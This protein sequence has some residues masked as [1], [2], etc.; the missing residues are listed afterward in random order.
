LTGCSSVP[1]QPAGASATP[2]MFVNY[3][4]AFKYIAAQERIPTD[5]GTLFRLAADSEI[6][7][8]HFDERPPL[9]VVTAHYYAGGLYDQIRGA[10]DNGRFYV[11]RTLA[12]DFTAVGNTDHG[13]QLIG[14]AEGNSYSWQTVNDR[15][16]LITRWHMSAAES[17]T[18][19]YDWEGMT[20][21]RSKE[22]K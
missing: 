4:A 20:Q 10:Q 21:L 6:R 13:F 7:V 19:T 12:H 14:V 22:V 2:D 3:Q 1:V 11:L 9:Y 5:A 16:K 8:W 18:N 17:G 15:L